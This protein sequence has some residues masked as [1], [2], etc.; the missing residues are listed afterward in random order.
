MRTFVLHRSRWR[1]TKQPVSRPHF[2]VRNQLAWGPVER[3]SEEQGA[4]FALPRHDAVI[5]AKRAHLPN[6]LF[7]VRG[8][9]VFL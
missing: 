6:F 7:L 9:S 8:A 5:R 3:A 2:D 1:F 4:V